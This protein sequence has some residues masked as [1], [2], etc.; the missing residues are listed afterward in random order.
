MPKIRLEG[1]TPGVPRKKDRETYLC[2][3]LNTKGKIVAIKIGLATTGESRRRIKSLQSG[4]LQK[5]ELLAV[6]RGNQ[7][8]KLHRTYAGWRMSRG[9]FFKPCKP[10]MDLIARTQELERLV[11]MLEAQEADSRH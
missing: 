8:R 9:E 7:E 4:C 11:E 3:V 6:L 2:G 10:L 5:L 1:G